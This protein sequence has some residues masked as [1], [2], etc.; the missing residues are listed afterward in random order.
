[1]SEV[2]GI[3][4]SDAGLG[5]LLTLVV[6]LILTGRLVPRRT[7]EDALADRDNW[8]AAYLESE[9]ARK[10]EHEHVAELLEMAKIGGHILTALPHPGHAD[11]EEVSGVDQMDQAS[12]ARP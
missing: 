4:A 12:R 7:H 9:A 10:V 1:M 11:E 5:A 6:L 3:T 8:R 2:F